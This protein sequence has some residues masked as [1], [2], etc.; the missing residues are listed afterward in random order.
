MARKT[1]KNVQGYDYFTVTATIN[2]K[3]EWFYGKGKQDAEAKRDAAKKAAAELAEQRRRLSN[4]SPDCTVKE[5]MR[6]WMFDVLRVSSDLKSTSFERYEQVYRLHVPAEVL[7]LTLRE[8]QALTIQRTFNELYETKT[9]TSEQLF[10]A[11]KLLVSFFNFC[12]A[13]EYIEKNPC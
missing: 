5:I 2:G 1:N 11:R 12:V 4:Y 13:E 3:R 6:V 9:K 10:H 7:N 8:A